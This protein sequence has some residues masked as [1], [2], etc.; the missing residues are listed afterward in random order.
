MGKTNAN[1]KLILGAIVA[2]VVVAATAYLQ[3]TLH[4]NTYVALAV[5]IV[6]ATLFLWFVNGGE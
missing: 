3:I 6:A 4:F 5:C 1:A 2:L